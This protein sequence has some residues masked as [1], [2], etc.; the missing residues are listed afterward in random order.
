MQ[1]GPKDRVA[2]NSPLGH[3]LGL[4]VKSNHV[5]DCGTRILY[6]DTPVLAE[7]NEAD[8][9]VRVELVFSVLENNNSLDT[10]GIDALPSNL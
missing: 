8:G 10:V 4:V 9:A 2:E 7:W 5:R 1:L 6:L 3:V